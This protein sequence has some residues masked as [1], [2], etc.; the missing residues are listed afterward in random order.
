MEI[1]KQ[2]VVMFF[3]K[4]NVYF[5]FYPSLLG[6]ESRQKDGKTQKRSHK[7]CDLFYNSIH[8][9]IAYVV[10]VF[11]FADGLCPLAII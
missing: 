7:K 1:L 2:K 8:F 6:Q 4:N 3:Q 10:T 9:L 11:K 5:Y